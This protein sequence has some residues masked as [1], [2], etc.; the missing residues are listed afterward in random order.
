MKARGSILALGLCGITAQVAGPIPRRVNA[1]DPVEGGAGCAGKNGDGNGDGSLMW[2]QATT[3]INQDGV[4]TP[5]PL[6][7]L[8]QDHGPDGVAWQEALKRCEDLHLAGQDD[9]RLP[10]A[11]ELESLLDYQRDEPYP[12]IS[13]AFRAEPACYWT[14]HARAL[15]ALGGL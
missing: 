15:Q 5:A 13:S 8:I 2:E 3:D 1:G 14:D 9:W 6:G 4:I 7:A 11:R 10:S 12:S